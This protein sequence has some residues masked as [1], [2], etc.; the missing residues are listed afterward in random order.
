MFF[1]YA[2]FDQPVRITGSIIDDN[3]CIS[4]ENAVIALLTQKD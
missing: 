4:V 2:S 3:Q 1:N